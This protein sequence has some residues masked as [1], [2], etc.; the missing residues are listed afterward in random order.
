MMNYRYNYC[1]YYV[2]LVLLSHVRLM[3]L[4]HKQFISLLILLTLIA[5]DGGDGLHVMGI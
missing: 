5:V 4:I 3:L 2:F 1:I